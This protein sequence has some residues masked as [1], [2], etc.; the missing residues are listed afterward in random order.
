MPY[1]PVLSKP[2]AK[3][4]VKE[5]RSQGYAVKT[6]HV[7]GVGNVVTKRKL[8]GTGIPSWAVLAGVGAL[9]W[10][11]LAP[12]KAFSL[13]ANQSYVYDARISPALP[14]SDVQRLGDYIASFGNDV[15]TIG[16]SHV[17]YIVHRSSSG[18]VERDKVL[19]NFEGSNI[20]LESVRPTAA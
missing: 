8:A 19:A 11:L 12:K 6:L 16:P 9:A 13:Q 20:V 15:V 14:A 17:Q 7:P 18:T 4:R 2:Q 5:L 10:I 1:V 3:N